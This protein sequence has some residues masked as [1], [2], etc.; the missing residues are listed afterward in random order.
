MG[1]RNPA[2]YLAPLA[3]I[4]TIAAIY[5]IVHTGLRSA[6]TPTVSVPATIAPAV[7]HRKFDKAPFYTVRPG[8]TLSGIALKTGVPLPTLQ[9][10]NPGVH[11]TAL[12]AGQRLKLRR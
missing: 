6:S 7:A 5:L 3:L 12:Q 9:A 10:L 4:A 2:R 8:D 1:A 11:P